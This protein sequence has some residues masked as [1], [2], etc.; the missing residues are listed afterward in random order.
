[1]CVWQVSAASFMLRQQQQPESEKA[2]E[3]RSGARDQKTSTSQSHVE[4]EQN[5]QSKAE[6]TAWAKESVLKAEQERRSNQCQPLFK[7]Y[8]QNAEEV[9]EGGGWDNRAMR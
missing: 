1:M 2:R 4:P 5:N 8:W 6:D 7:E 9:K 3:A